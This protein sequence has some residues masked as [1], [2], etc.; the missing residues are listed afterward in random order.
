MGFKLQI[1]VNDIRLDL[2]EDETIELNR[3]IKEVQDIT[4]VFSEFT[5]SFNVPA[6][7]TNNK[8]FKHYYRQDLIDSIDDSQRLDTVLLLDGIPF[9]FGGV[10]VNDVTIKS[11]KPLHYNITFYDNTTK[12]KT[13]IGDDTFRDLDFSEYTHPYDL[14]TVTSGL[15]SGLFGGEMVYPLYA[16]NQPY[17]FNDNFTD[18]NNINYDNPS[19]TSGDTA[20]LRF[21]TLKPAIQ[22][23][24]IVD[25]I[26]ETYDITLGG[27]F[28]NTS[29]VDLNSQFDKTYMWT[30]HYKETI[31]DSQTE[32]NY[33]YYPSYQEEVTAG[34]GG[35]FDMD[36]GIYEVTSSVVLTDVEFRFHYTSLNIRGT[37][38][39][40]VN[41][42]VF[43]SATLV[44]TS[45][46]TV[47]IFP[48]KT[49]LVQNDTVQLQLLFPA[50]QHTINIRRWYAYETSGSFPA[51]AFYKRNDVAYTYFADI[52]VNNELPPMKVIDF[53]NSLIKLFNLV[54]TSKDGKTFEFIKYNRYFNGELVNLDRYVDTSNY[55]VAS[56]NKFKSINFKFDE[57][58]S[59]DNEEFSNINDRFFGNI[60]TEL[61]N[62]ESDDLTF[63]LP[64]SIPLTVKPYYSSS[65]T[66]YEG[67]TK[68]PVFRCFKLDESESVEVAVG[69]PVLF[70]L[71]GDIAL[72]TTAGDRT[73]IGITDAPYD[74]NEPQSGTTSGHTINLVDSI[75]ET[76]PVLKFN[77]GS[78][79][80][81]SLTYSGDNESYFGEI[82]YDG[83]VNQTL[84]NPNWSDYINDLYNSKTRLVKINAYLPTSIL[85]RL[86]LN[87]LVLIKNRKYRINKMKSN[88]TTGKT[89]FE[90]INVV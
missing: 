54:V 26:N 6:S 68:F 14:D 88:L 53:I 31:I 90:L 62:K 75:K 65:T 25:K 39:V 66:S 81:F 84:Y 17:N 13:I 37:A 16:T 24:K 30:H 57:L 61:D 87:N 89:S 72:G 80:Y 41:G 32:Y 22:L 48:D 69:K 85:L 8:V 49:D 10:E 52:E 3:S 7:N 70:Y 82:T 23:R 27:E 20:G 28:F 51:T 47:V 45:V 63:D 12:I 58:E 11:G 79:R 59:I 73:R 56:I 33:A 76:L 74:I 1:L 36:T 86:N 40:L 43:S 19:P 38:N 21:Y 77:D 4:K 46:E 60:E 71:G 42:E 9:K 67:L 18:I 55:T 15:T 78:D 83:V 2:F 34:F 5:T 64:Y 35:T 44:P 29:D 50:K